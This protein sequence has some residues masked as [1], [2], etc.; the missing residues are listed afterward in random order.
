MS[1]Y[2]D[3]FTVLIDAC[4]LA[5]ALRRNM[6]LS[7]AEA[8]FYRVR[9]SA[10]IMSET[11]QAIEKITQGR[12]DP[13]KQTNA[14]NRAFP[15]AIV[16]GYEDLE[17]AIVEFGLKDEDDAHVVAAATA[18]SASVIVTDNLKDFPATLLM[19]YGLEA[20]SAD[21]FLADCIDLDNVQAMAALNKMRLRFRHPE[22]TW[23]AICQK[24]EAQGLTQSASLMQ[25]F[26]DVIN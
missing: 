21:D 16:E 22:Y 8:G 23:D 4:C 25:A 17:K 10:R 15:E 12:A 1:H 7:L 26:S 9:W 24:V 20:K 2:A 3:R 11:A 19:R 18:C 14:M 5:G 13:Q 6:L